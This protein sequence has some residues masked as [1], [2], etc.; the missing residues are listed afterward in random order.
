MKLDISA[1]YS[2]KSAEKLFLEVLLDYVCQLY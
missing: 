2:N 1:K